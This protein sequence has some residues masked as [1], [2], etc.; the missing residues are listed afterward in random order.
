MGAPPL[1]FVFAVCGNA[2]NEQCP[3][4]P[5]RPITANWII[6]DPAAVQG[7]EE[8]KL[9]AFQRALRELS[10]RIQL[11]TSFAAEELENLAIKKRLDEIGRS[12]LSA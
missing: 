5:G 3:S 2:A 12:T 6:D 1:H 9:L 8:Q 10:V 4:W 7:T 11:F